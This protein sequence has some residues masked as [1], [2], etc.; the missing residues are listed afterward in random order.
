[1]TDETK[2]AEPVA[3]LDCALG[4]LASG[5]PVQAALLLT[6]SEPAFTVQVPEITAPA[7]VGLKN[8]WRAPGTTKKDSPC[9]RIFCSFFPTCSPNSPARAVKARPRTRSCST[10]P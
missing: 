5:T 1:M 3:L 6:K 7:P 8:A 2:T 9:C 4:S 10:R